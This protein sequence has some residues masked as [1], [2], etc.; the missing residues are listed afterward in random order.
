MMVAGSWLD[1]GPLFDALIAHGA[2]VNARDSRGETALSKACD[3]YEI[4]LMRR[5]L[6]H[7]ADPNLADTDG[8]TPLMRASSERSWAWSRSS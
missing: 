2:E 8:Y 3:E 5:L 7:G 1:S 6:E 4:T